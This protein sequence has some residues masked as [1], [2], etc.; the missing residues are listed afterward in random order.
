M[1][2]AE[3]MIGLFGWN[4]STVERQTEGLTH[5]DSLL[6][7]PRFRTNVARFQASFHRY[8]EDH[9]AERAVAALLTPTG[10][11]P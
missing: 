9:V 4:A 7:D 1:T 8:R 3:T 6:H 2:P 10:G 5:A 11:G